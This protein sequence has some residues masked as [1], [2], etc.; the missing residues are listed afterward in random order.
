MKDSVAS[1][2]YKRWIQLYVEKFRIQP[3]LET[4]ILIV[5]LV[6]QTMDL[7]EVSPWAKSHK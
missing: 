3:T 7:N 5:Q 1:D 2:L 6:Q 4:R